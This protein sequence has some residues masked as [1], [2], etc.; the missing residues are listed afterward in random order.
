[1]FTVIGNIVLMYVGHLG[2]RQIL[3]RQYALG[4]KQHMYLLT[5]SDRVEKVLEQL[6]SSEEICPYAV[7]IAILD[8]DRRGE[9]I[10]GFPG[11][12]GQ[13]RIYLTMQEE[14][15]SMSPILTF[16]I[17]QANP[18]KVLLKSLKKWE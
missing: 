17:Q 8:K 11:S 4:D 15:L 9:V 7:R 5:T 3:K 14:K 18:W 2:I 6:K 16:H 10:G 12:S 13:R 1:M